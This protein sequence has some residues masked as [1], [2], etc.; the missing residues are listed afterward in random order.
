MS[1]LVVYLLL[2]VLRLVRMFF[3]WLEVKCWV[4]V[5]VLWV[6]CVLGGVIESVVSILFGLC[7]VVICVLV[8]V[9]WLDGR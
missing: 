9:S 8:L 3:R 7:L 1:F 2:L 6:I 4:I 5:W